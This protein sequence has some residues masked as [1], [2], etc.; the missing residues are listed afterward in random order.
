MQTEVPGAITRTRAA[1]RKA[2]RRVAAVFARYAVLGLA[3][4]SVV[5]ACSVLAAQ[6]PAPHDQ[7][8]A[9]GGA[10]GTRLRRQQT[11][12]PGGQEQAGA[13]EVGLPLPPRVNARPFKDLLERWGAQYRVG[14]LDTGGDFDITF[15]SDERARSMASVYGL[16]LEFERA[17]RRG[18]DA[19]LVW[20]KTK[21]SASGKALTVELEIPRQTLGNLLLRQITPN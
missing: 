17:G 21:V 19:G 20:D 7:P 4:L 16:G 15:E 11:P 13:A 6:T 9:Q 14:R 2:S 1:G 5:P 3:S 8:N 18:T 10:E 12:T